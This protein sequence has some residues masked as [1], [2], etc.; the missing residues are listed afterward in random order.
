MA[1]GRKKINMI[2]WVND[3]DGSWKTNEADVDRIFIDYFR[4]IFTSSNPSTEQMDQIVQC[5]PCKITTRMNVILTAS[6]S[7]NEI[8]KALKQMQP[9]KAPDPDSFPAL[10]YQKY[11]EVVGN[12]TVESCL[13]ILNRER[14]VRDWNDTHIPLIPKIQNPKEVGDYRPINLYNVTYKL[15]TKVL[16]TG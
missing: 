4:S 6:F 11:W 2:L 7:R 10:F 1:S 16:A 12:K 8:F 13:Q 9:A 3:F 15:V 5:T 14:S